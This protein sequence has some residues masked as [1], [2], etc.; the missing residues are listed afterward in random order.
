MKIF[1]FDDGDALVQ[2]LVSGA[3]V[4]QDSDVYYLPPETYRG[5]K[6]I[7]EFFLGAL[8]TKNWRNARPSLGGGSYSLKTLAQNTA[9]SMVALFLIH[10]NVKLSAHSCRQDEDGIELLK[11]I[12]LTEGLGEWRKAHVAICSFE[13]P[14]A[15]LRRKPQNLIFLSE[16]TTFL[17][18]PE[19]IDHLH[20]TA[21]LAALA[22]K[23]A[24]IIH[25]YLAPFVQ[26]DYRTPDA[27][28]AFS[29]WWGLHQL[30]TARQAIA[31]KQEVHFPH[32]VVENLRLLENKKARFLYGVA[33][34]PQAAADLI[35][36]DFPRGEFRIVCVDDERDWGEALRAALEATSKRRVQVKTPQLPSQREI[37]EDWIAKEIVSSGAGGPDLVLLDLRLKGNKELHVPVGETSGAKVARIIR[38]LSPGLPIILMTASNK[39]WTFEEAM[40]LGIDGYW[41]KEGIGEHMPAGG[42]AQNYLMLL[43]LVSTALG[44]E[45]Q[46]LRRYSQAVDEIKAEASPWW[47]NHLWLGGDEA[48]TEPEGIHRVLDGTLILLREYLRLFRM[49][50]G[51][52]G[53]S[54]AIEQSWISAL[55]VEANKALELTHRSGAG[56]QSTAE[57][58]TQFQLLKKR[59]DGWGLDLNTQRNSA[60]HTGSGVVEFGL[61]QSALAGVATWLLI[62]PSDRGQTAFNIRNSPKYKQIYGASV[63]R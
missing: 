6:S 14:Q 44:E 51:F 53:Q 26:C 24:D 43:R 60:A 3:V 22:E 55:I 48:K 46:F 12:R 54:N 11:H 33:D 35:V 15:L 32:C 49:G 5:H 63:A 61:A 20:G 28:H 13:D 27:A 10:V 34:P 50:Y 52:R 56:P 9:D 30:A 17:R 41:M 45:Y 21:Y 16:G 57:R 62:S 7:D 42:S 59:D 38:D 19:A 40:K 8:E 47:V 58:N 39:A 25:G 37:D 2:L 36:P 1:V 31:G 4:G 18:L 23:K 29:N